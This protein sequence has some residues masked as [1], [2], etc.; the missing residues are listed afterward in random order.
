M[1]GVV[2]YREGVEIAQQ[3]GGHAGTTNNQMELTAL[4]VAIERAGQLSGNSGELVTIWSDSQYCAN[5]V[6]EWLAGWKR[7]KS[8]SPNR[9][10]GEIKNLELWQAIDAVLGDA[11]TTSTL[12]IRWGKG[13]AGIA[14]NER[15]DELAE[16][17]RQ[18]AIEMRAGLLT[19]SDELDER[20]RQIMGAA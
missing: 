3:C 1:W 18:E 20:Y 2:I 5:G 11:L 12:A 13:H 4:L 15:A 7:K 8:N 19:S 10:A 14:G 6:N 9:A 17:G 16:M